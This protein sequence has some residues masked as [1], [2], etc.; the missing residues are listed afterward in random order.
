MNTHH[1]SLRNGSPHAA[2]RRQARRQ[3]HAGAR[4]CLPERHP[5]ADAPA[6]HAARA[7]CGGRPQHGG[8]RVGVPGLAAQQHGQDAV[9]G[10]RPARAASHPFPAGAERGARGDGRLGLAAGDAR[11][12][13]AL[14]GRV[15][16]VVRQVGG[17]RALR[18]RA[19]A[20]QF[21]GRGAVR[22]RAARLRRRPHGALLHRRHAERDDAQLAA[23]SRARAVRRAGVPGPRRARLRD[24]ALLG[25]VARVQGAR[26]HDR[27]LGVGERGPGAHHRA[28]P[29]GLHAAARRSR[30]APARPAAVDGA[31]HPRPAP[32]GGARVRAREPAQLRRVRQP[33]GAAR[34]RRGGQVVP[35][36]ATGARAPRHRRAGRRAHRHPRVQAGAHVAARAAGTARVRARPRGDPRR[37][38]EAPDHR[39]PDPRAALPLARRAATAHRRQARRAV[40]PQRVAAAAQRRAVRRAGRAGDRR[41]A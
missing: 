35:R 40:R 13:R 5:G 28:H 23:R 7:R 39:G 11:P 3:V 32:A 2:R 10:A 1:R 41:A 29:R 22:R 17:A 14:P 20:R 24:V 16:H 18:R 25:L 38:G 37:R 15:R 27:M 4:P 36:R 26:R 31:A 6:H 34:H 12:A 30:P 21:G 33:A 9:G 8:L 19:A